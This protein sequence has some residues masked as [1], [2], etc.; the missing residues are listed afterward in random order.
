MTRSIESHGRRR[1]PHRPQSWAGLLAL[2][3]L[4][5]G[6]NLMPRVPEPAPPPVVVPPPPAPTPAPTPPPVPQPD[7]ADLA[8]RQFLAF[9]DRLRQMAPSELA[10][11]QALPAVD[12]LV[13]PGRALEQAL[14]LG[15]DRN[16]G[17]LGRALA[18]I[19]PLLSSP[20]P[21]LAPW[22]PLARLLR[23]R[24]SEQRRLDELAERQAQQLRE[25]QRRI[26]QLSSQLEALKAIE[27]SLAPR[28]ALAPPAPPTPGAPGAPGGRQP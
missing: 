16:P 7:P 26:E 25:Q 1:A 9:Q 8:A 4:A 21:T 10:R 11:E 12:P 18:L 6:C 28:P 23:D 15:L 2:G 24:L 20:Q 17:D 13:Q 19:D 3:V 5:G 14:V 27:R 22:L